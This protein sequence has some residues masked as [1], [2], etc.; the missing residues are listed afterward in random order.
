MVES[1]AVWHSLLESK[2]RCLF[3]PSPPVEV[4]KRVTQGQKSQVEGSGDIPTW[5]KP[6]QVHAL[7]DAVHRASPEYLQ[8]RDELLVLLAYDTGVR[9]GELVALDVE[10]VHLEDE[11]VGP[12]IFLT[13]EIQKG[14]DPQPRQIVLRPDLGTARTLRHYLRDRWRDGPALFP[15]RSSPRMSTQAARDVVRKLAL[16]AGVR[17]R[18][19]EDNVEVG[20]EHV[21]PHSLRHSLFYREFVQD[22]R[23][24]KEVSLR[25]RHTKVATTEETYA[26][27]IAV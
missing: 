11:D 23:R 8:L 27:L 12:Y 14:E 18:R 5:L 4:Y 10:H 20:P 22:E 25:L 6:E 13:E 16:E 2:V 19:T 21:S 26:N 1:L 3:P 24:L 17:P 15:S 9:V 7:L